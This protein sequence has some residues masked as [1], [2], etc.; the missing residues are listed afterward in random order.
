MRVYR[1][2]LLGFVAYFLVA[3]QSPAPVEE[4]VSVVAKPKSQGTSAVQQLRLQAS[5]AQTEGRVT[6][7]IAIL[8]RALRID[9]NNPWL[10]L[11][12]ARLYYNS[13]N[14]SQSQQIANKGRNVLLA[15][16]G[17]LPTKDYEQLADQFEQLSR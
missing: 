12:L 1:V 3:C 11:D 14:I 10:Y 7:A 6:Q 5:Q 4:A 13:S 15:W 8:E 16:K 17:V 9:G 2:L